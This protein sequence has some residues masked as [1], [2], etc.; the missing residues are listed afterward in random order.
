MNWSKI[1]NQICDHL[2]QRKLGDQAKYL[3]EAL[4]I[5]ATG[6]EIFD[7]AITRLIE[8]KRKGFLEDV[9][10]EVLAII[11]YAKSIEHL[12]HDFEI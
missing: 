6:G 9:S 8:L 1:Y 3:K 7:I 12:S 10:D 2:E 5:G 11:N 4:V